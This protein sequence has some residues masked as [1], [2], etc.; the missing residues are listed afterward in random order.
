MRGRGLPLSTHVVPVGDGF[1]VALV[2]D[3]IDQAESSSLISAVENKTF[4][5]LDWLHD[6]G[7]IAMLIGTDG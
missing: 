6:Q 5:A 7:V 2:A 3:P 1:L 4:K